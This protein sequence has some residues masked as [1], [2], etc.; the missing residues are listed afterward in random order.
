MPEDH[1]LSALYDCYS[2]FTATLNNNKCRKERRSH[3]SIISKCCSSATFITVFTNHPQSVEGHNVRKGICCPDSLT[4]VTTR[5]LFLYLID[6]PC[7]ALVVVAL[8]PGETESV[9]KKRNKYELK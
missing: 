5:N 2:I 4:N 3:F 6:G 9:V 8:K 7:L 1:P